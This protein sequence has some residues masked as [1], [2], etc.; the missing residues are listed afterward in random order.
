MECDKKGSPLSHEVQGR[1]LLTRGSWG[2]RA[3]IRHATRALNDGRSIRRMILAALILTVVGGVAVLSAQQQTPTFEAVS[4]KR[5][6]DAAGPV[7]I[8]QLPGGG[9]TITNGT[10]SLLMGQ[11]YPVFTWEIV[12]MPDWATTERYDVTATGDSTISMP[13]QAQRTDMLRAML[14]DRFKL[15][16]HF[17]TREQSVYQLVFAR[18]DQRLGPGMKPTDANCVAIRAAAEAARAAGQPRSPTVPPCSAT[19]GFNRIDGDTTIDTLALQLRSML[20]RA[21]IDKTG[22]AGYYHFTFDFGATEL[23][24]VS[25]ADSGK[26]SI[27]TALQEQLGLKLEATRG[28][29]E[30]LVI[31]S[32][33]RPTPN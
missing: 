19:I 1:A 10:F 4:I 22:L 18:A 33:D 14:A 9:F 16:T 2:T 12:G 23:N 11:S 15:R 31:D 13:T 27:F 3:A 7:G 20:R 30:V 25:P 32:V 6:L 29:V 26:P 28:P 21:V 8:R 17:E 24:A 5:N